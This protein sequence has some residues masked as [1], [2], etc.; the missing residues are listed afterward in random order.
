MKVNT[1]TQTVEVT[2]SNAVVL[3]IFLH[4]VYG[5]AKTAAGKSLTFYKAF[6]SLVGI[7]DVE[8]VKIANRYAK[9]EDRITTEE[10]RKCLPTIFAEFARV[11]LETNGED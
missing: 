5:D 6:G 8:A 10:F 1:I 4:A 11:M 2:I 3:D 7:S 9:K